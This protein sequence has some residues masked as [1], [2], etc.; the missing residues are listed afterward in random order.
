MVKA[1]AVC[2]RHCCIDQ[3]WQLA[4]S[5]VRRGPA[6]RHTLKLSNRSIPPRVR[7]PRPAVDTRFLNGR[8]IAVCIMLCCRS[9]VSRTHDHANVKGAGRKPSATAKISSSADT[10][11]CGAACPFRMNLADVLPADQVAR[12]DGP[13]RLASHLVRLTLHK[14][15]ILK[16]LVARSWNTVYVGRRRSMMVP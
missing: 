10:R 11:T 1:D 9:G 13:D 16:A 6:D 8:G 15:W 3:R 7:S 2:Q 4:T 5:R 14:R 12:K